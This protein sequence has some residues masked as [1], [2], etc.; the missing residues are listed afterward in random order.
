MTKTLREIDSGLFELQKATGDMVF[1]LMSSPN[2]DQDYAARLMDAH[3]RLMQ[4][5]VD[6]G[7]LCSETP[8][9]ATAPVE[10]LSTGGDEEYK[11]F[12]GR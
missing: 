7:K 4:V 6:I 9:I 2:V 3:L 1:G 5:W 11:R 10:I 8:G 12:M